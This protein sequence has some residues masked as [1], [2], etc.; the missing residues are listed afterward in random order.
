MV[1]VTAAATAVAGATQGKDEEETS[2][3]EHAPGNFSP[4]HSDVGHVYVGRLCLREQDIR[5]S[6]CSS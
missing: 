4:N 1:V 5:V 3:V 2:T 6:R